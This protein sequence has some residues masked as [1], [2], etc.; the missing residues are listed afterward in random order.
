MRS[1]NH[2]TRLPRLQVRTG[3]D[4]DMQDGMARV[5]VHMREAQSW[6]GRS[7]TTA[8]LEFLLYSQVRGATV[9]REGAGVQPEIHTAAGDTL[10]PLPEFPIRLEFVESAGRVRTLLPRLQEMAGAALI[11]VQPVTLAAGNSAPEMPPSCSEARPC[12]AL[13]IWVGAGDRWRNAPLHEALVESLRAYGISGATVLRSVAGYA[14]LCQG[15]PLLVMAV[16]SPERVQAWLPVLQEMAPQAIA[17]LQA[18]EQLRS[19]AVQQGDRE[20]A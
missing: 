1:R 8:L 15:T 9:T 18:A 6:R 11:E 13:S 2:P 5:I 20:A 7:L 19:F 12:V 3:A 17:V 14:G 4:T 16:D 10:H